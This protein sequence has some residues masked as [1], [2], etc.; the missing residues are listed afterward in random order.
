MKE[1]TDKSI[2]ETRVLAHKI[3]MEMICIECDADGVME[4][5]GEV[6]GVTGVAYDG[7]GVMDCICIGGGIP[8]VIVD[9]EGIADII[10]DVL[11]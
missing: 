7:K 6:E 9:D 10:V 3:G 8:G 11:N 4:V 2:V 1:W 5:V